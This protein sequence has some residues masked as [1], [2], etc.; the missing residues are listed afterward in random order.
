MIMS[1]PRT[2]AIARHLLAAYDTAAVIPLITEDRPEFDVEAA[3]AV[4]ADIERLRRTRG[5]RAVGR[6]IGFTNRAIWERYNVDRPMW[7]RMWSRTVIMAPDGRARLSLA[8]LVQ[9]RIEPEVVFRLRGPVA[10]V[11]DPRE[12]LGSTEWVAPGF[13]IVHCHYPDWRFT[14]ADCTADFGLHGALVVGTP[15]PVT[16]D[17]RAALAERLA[18]FTLT[19]RHGATIV[20]TG[21][22]A[23]VLGHPVRALAHLARLLETQPAFEPLAPGEIV[24]T[25][26]LTDAPPIVAGETWSS[27]YGS[28]GLPGLE[29]QLR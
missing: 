8:G 18:T 20:D 29:L 11:D 13:E 19:L 22:G 21:V 6:K 26:T 2:D 3:Y 25:G 14:A 16:P 27:D 23:N 5:W 1:V 15:W 17:N 24:T 10:L 12:L 7:A 9:P 4:L 28:S